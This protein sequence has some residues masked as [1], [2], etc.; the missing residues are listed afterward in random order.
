METIS[1]NNKNTMDSYKTA[2]EYK[3]E[4]FTSKNENNFSNLKSKR[5]LYI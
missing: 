3:L 2:L 5:K 4:A 1:A